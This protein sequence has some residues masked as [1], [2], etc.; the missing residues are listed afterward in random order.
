META[1]PYSA[2]HLKFYFF[3]TGVFNALRLS[4]QLDRPEE[5]GGQAL[6]G[7]VAQ[8]LR[9][10]ID[11]RHP[12]ANLYYWRTSAGTEVDFV[13]YGKDLFWAIEVKNAAHVQP[14]DL[15]ALRTFGEDYP[16]A[17]RFLLYRGRE[18]LLRDGTT[19]QPWQ[20]F[21]LGLA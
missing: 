1:T 11:Y 6:E 15:K 5:K 7:L 10:W 18:K 4:G 16:E 2:Q 14:R 8:H 20:E 17:K 19:I 12:A 3:D 13:V 21:L 9:A